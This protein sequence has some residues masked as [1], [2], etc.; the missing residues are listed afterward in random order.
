MSESNPFSDPKSQPNIREGTSPPSAV[1]HN[2][3]LDADLIN[4]ITSRS[5]ARYLIWVVPALALAAGIGIGIALDRLVLP[6][7][8]PDLVVSEQRNH[9]V[10]KEN[11]IKIKPEMSSWEVTDLLGSGEIVKEDGLIIDAQGNFKKYT[12]GS[13]VYNETTGTVNGHDGKPKQEIKQEI[14][15]RDGSKAIYLTL[16]NNKVVSKREEGLYRE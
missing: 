12:R 7:N 6:H 11:Y 5:R 9:N 1:A 16:S 2:P 8:S 13:G 10:T 15:W 3:A 4:R 14:V